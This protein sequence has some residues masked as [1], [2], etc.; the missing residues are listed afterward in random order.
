MSEQSEQVTTEKVMEVK[1]LKPVASIS[2]DLTKHHKKETEIESAKIVQVPSNFAEC[3]TQWVL[4]VQSVVLEEIGEGDEKIEFRASELFN[5]AQD[6][7]GKLTGYPDSKDSNLVKFMKDMNVEH[8][9]E[10]KGKKAT[11]KAYEKGVEGN[12]KT[13]LK[14][15]Y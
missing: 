5:L 10:L 14:F 11:I 6:K 8:P 15:L 2:V 4:K 7:Q 9:D 12:T 1:D 13:Y 3:G